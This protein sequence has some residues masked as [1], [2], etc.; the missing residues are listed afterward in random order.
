MIAAVVALHKRL[1]PDHAQSGI[2][3]F[4][5]RIIHIAGSSVSGLD[6]D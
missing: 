3:P 2:E 1:G 4:G 5:K 6:N